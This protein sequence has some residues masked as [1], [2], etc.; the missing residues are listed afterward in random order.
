MLSWL[1]LPGSDQSVEYIQV[2]PGP[3]RDEG[4]ADPEA[5]ARTGLRA[6]LDQV[7]KLSSPIEKGR[8]LLAHVRSK[9]RYLDDQVDH[10]GF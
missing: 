8:R 3:W 10:R 2:L 9:E 4:Q 7:A 6:L 5:W 1:F